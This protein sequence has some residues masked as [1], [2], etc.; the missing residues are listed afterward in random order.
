MRAESIT[1][2]A[3]SLLGGDPVNTIPGEEE[4]SSGSTEEGRE[5][6]KT[7]ATTRTTFGD[8]DETDD[9]F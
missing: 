1:S 7:A 2:G 5:E 9:N 8:G 4:A 3:R 6:N